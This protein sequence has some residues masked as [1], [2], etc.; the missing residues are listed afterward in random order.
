MNNNY[1]AP[2]STLVNTQ[3][4]AGSLEAAIAGDYEFSVMDTISEAWSNTKGIKRYIIGAGILLYVVLGF[5]LGILMA[6][7]M[8]ASMGS[9]PDPF[10]MLGIQLVMQPVM[11]AVMMPFVGGIVVMCLKQI[12]GREV[13]FGDLFSVFNK[14]LP[15][16]LAAIL[17][18][19][20]VSI[21]F[22]LLILPG[23]YLGVC[24][25]MVVPLIIDRDLGVWEAMEASRKAITKRW[26][27]VF[28]LY[29]LLFL[30]M[31]ISMIPLGIGLLWTIPLMAMAFMTMYEKMFGIASY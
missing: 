1:S 15:L 16:F 12:Q 28:G 27:S 7:L 13:G 18:N 8:P 26:F 25:L 19:I 10:T 29:L 24:Y 3:G 9:E 22:V 21:G 2:S 11:F 6:F 30:I 14:T 5:V 20:M 4:S 23:I 31:F 17:I